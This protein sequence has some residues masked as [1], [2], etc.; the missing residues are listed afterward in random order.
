MLFNM[1]MKKLAHSLSNFGVYDNVWHQTLD[2]LVPVQMDQWY[3]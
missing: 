3:L 2:V 1:A